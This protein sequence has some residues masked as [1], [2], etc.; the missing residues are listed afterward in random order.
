MIIN[1]HSY[2]L[3][4]KFPP[5]FFTYK[6]SFDYYIFHFI[7]Q[8]VDHLNYILNNF[9]FN[10]LILNIFFKRMVILNF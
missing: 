8:I 9:Q 4:I 7:Y 3:L 5:L 2:F 1:V 10:Y 6:N